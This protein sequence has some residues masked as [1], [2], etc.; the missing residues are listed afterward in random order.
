ML[1]NNFCECVSYSA[2]ASMIFS[3]NNDSEALKNDA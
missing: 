1:S 2:I 3:I